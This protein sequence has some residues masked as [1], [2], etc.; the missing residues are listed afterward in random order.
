[1]NFVFQEYLK[2]HQRRM[3]EFG[4]R[5]YM[6]GDYPELPRHYPGVRVVYEWDQI[7]AVTDRLYYIPQRWTY[8]RDHLTLPTAKARRELPAQDIDYA[9]SA[10]LRGV[11]SYAESQRRATSPSPCRPPGATRPPHPGSAVSRAISQGS[12]LTS[13]TRS[14]RQRPRTCLPRAR[15]PQPGEEQPPVQLVPLLPRKPP[16]GL[17]PRSQTPSSQCSAQTLDSTD[18]D[19]RFRR[20]LTRNS[21]YTQRPSRSHSRPATATTTTETRRNRSLRR[22]STGVSRRTRWSDIADDTD[23]LNSSI[24]ELLQTISATDGKLKPLSPRAD[25]RQTQK[26]RTGSPESCYSRYPNTA[27]KGSPRSDSGFDYTQRVLSNFESIG[28]NCSD[29]TKGEYDTS[30]HAGDYTEEMTHSQSKFTICNSDHQETQIKNDNKTKDFDSWQMPGHSFFTSEQVNGETKT[31]P[32]QTNNS[33]CIDFGE[34]QKNAKLFT[35]NNSAV[36]ASGNTPSMHESELGCKDHFKSLTPKHAT[37][38]TSGALE[39]SSVPMPKDQEAFKNGM[40]LQKSSHISEGWVK[41]GSSKVDG[42][43]VIE[44]AHLNSPTINHDESE[45]SSDLSE[46][47]DVLAPVGNLQI[48]LSPSQSSSTGRTSSGESSSQAEYLVVSGTSNTGTEMEDQDQ[49]HTY[50]KQKDDDTAQP[51]KNERGEDS[52]S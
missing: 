41:N 49:V 3:K 29:S 52:D 15:T 25:R 30:V 14:G 22:P 13:Q 7:D 28:M 35:Q 4:P 46:S 10:T 23:S 34:D 16:S 50:I 11:V 1:M 38:H 44:K 6:T 21:N 9:K 24:L 20:P 45:K 48:P 47:I 39:K 32:C 26:G 18:I 12:N 8:H 17:P 31:G 36:A 27:V 5:P 51:D 19:H 37:N 33:V 2:A 42:T 40:S 43:A